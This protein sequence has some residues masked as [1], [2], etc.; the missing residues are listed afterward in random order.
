MVVSENL[1]IKVGGSKDKELWWKRRL[2]N[3]MKQ[4][5]K[6]ISKVQRLK[7]GTWIKTTFRE[8]LQKKYWLKE[9]G[10]KVCYRGI[11]TMSHSKGSQSQ[12]V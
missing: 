8:D 2:E 11:E 1:G 9:K 4:L 6:D 10:Y 3:K 12:K 5:R 7:E